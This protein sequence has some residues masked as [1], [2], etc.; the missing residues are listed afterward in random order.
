MSLLLDA[1]K[2]AAEQKAEKSREE[3]REGRPS[4]ETQLNLP[5]ED[6]SELEQADEALARRARRAGRDETELDQSELTELKTG[7]EQDQQQRE[8]SDETG[9]D[10]SAD[11]DADLSEVGHVPAAGQDKQETQLE[12]GEE[13]ITQAPSLSDQMQTGEDETIIFAEE[14][15]ADFL[16]E[17]A[18]I[19]RDPKPS[20]DE[21]DLS[22]LA[23]TRD[24]TQLKS[25]PPDA[26]E[27][28][29]SKFGEDEDESKLNVAVPDEDETGLSRFGEDEDDSHLRV[30]A[31]AEDETDL[32]QV[33]REDDDLQTGR[34]RLADEGVD[35]TDD[36]D[37]SL[38]PQNEDMSLLLVE[39]DDTDISTRT[40]AT[41][42]RHPGHLASLAAAEAT[43]T[44]GIGLVEKADQTS[45]VMAGSDS[46]ATTSMSPGR[47]ND[48][49]L[50]RS[51]ST[52]TRTYAPDNY[53]RT[54]MKLPNEDASKLFAGMKAEADV[55]MT[56]DYAK[57]VFQSKSSAQRLQHYKFYSG[58]AI[59]ILLTIGIFGLFEYQYESDSIDTSLRPLKRDP[60]PGVIKQQSNQE[61]S[62]LFANNATEEVDS[63][64]LE[65]IE[66]L[67]TQG[68]G[69]IASGETVQDES[70]SADVTATVETPS[71]PVAVSDSQTD[72]SEPLARVD[73]TQ[74]QAVAEEA[75]SK[76][77]DKPASNLQITSS[78]RL[79]EKSIL[80]REAYAAYQ[81]GNDGVA[82]DKY[83]EVLKLDPGNR[84]AL[85]ARAAINVQNN[86]SNAA[87]NDY[88]ALLLANPKDSLAMT[89]LVS[90]ASLSPEESESQLKLMIRDEPDSPYLNFALA[91]V[92]GAQN[93]WQ[94]AQGLYFK[95]LERN[96]GDANYA[97][98]LA[99]SLEH[100]AKPRVAI[101][102][103]QRAL[104]NYETSLTTFSKD[105]VNQ[106]LELLRK[107]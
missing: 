16:G 27:T 26:D 2:K 15:V 64:T 72:S 8:Q 85:L 14:D 77:V 4:D 55:V 94:E 42:P 97:Y 90:V 74:K 46:T 17:P 106:R 89:S 41:D 32:S 47:G 103:Y 43:V 33:I 3:S 29:L 104:D 81:T 79:E 49:T 75:V 6:I 69:V 76:V 25:A 9:L 88:Q 105:V 71:Q 10:A 58:I 45:T 22:Q 52:S 30:A 84:N 93:R 24:D 7:L 73:T 68:Q 98:N 1:L 82:L 83:N 35:D 57:K 59:V 102:Y 92:Y 50:T 53:D 61:S 100:I 65:I 44:G 11:E 101:A 19:R 23:E 95:A 13:T 91:N 107:L 78:K 34:S 87:I 60:M 36:E 96:P 63:R 40:S 37:P 12:I 80:L 51:D 21:T 18:L 5:R 99:V 66:N 38:Q 56:P 67:Q 54:L 31:P 28:G 20:E 39:R 70:G 86:N 48:S 62:S